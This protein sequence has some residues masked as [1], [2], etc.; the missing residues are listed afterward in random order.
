[1]KL[2]VIFFFFWIRW[3]KSKRSGIKVLGFFHCVFPPVFSLDEIYIDRKLCWSSVLAKCFLRKKGL[4]PIHGK[5]LFELLGYGLLA[6]LILYYSLCFKPTTATGFLKCLLLFQ[7]EEGLVHFQWLDRTQNVVEDVS[8]VF[9]PQFCTLGHHHLSGCTIRFL[10]FWCKYFV[11]S[12]FFCC[13]SLQV[14]V[15][16]FWFVRLIEYSDEIDIRK[17]RGWISDRRNLRL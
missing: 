10:P 16:W 2:M 8:F 6:Y 5:D 12:R 1:M 17:F 11:L 4:F 15:F 14:N 7:G 9:P 3:M 13:Y